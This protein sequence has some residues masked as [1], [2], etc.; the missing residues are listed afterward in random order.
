MKATTISN[1]N[2]STTTTNNYKAEFTYESCAF[3]APPVS[4]HPASLLMLG[5]LKR[6][7]IVTFTE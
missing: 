4:S 7:C 2:T 1:T 5:E 6:S 3:L